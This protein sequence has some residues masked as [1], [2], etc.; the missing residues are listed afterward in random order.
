MAFAAIRP[1][2]FSRVL[3]RSIVRNVGALNF[4]SSSKSEEEAAAPPAAPAYPSFGEAMKTRAT[5]TLEV[6]VSKLFPAGFGWQAAGYFGDVS[7]GLTDTQISFFLVTGMGDLLGVFGGHCIYN[8]IKKAT[9]MGK[10]INMGDEVQTGFM[11]GTAA[12][13]SGTAW[14]PTVNMMGS[15]NLEFIPA[16]VGTGLMTGPAFFFGLRF[17]RHVYPNL[18]MSAIAR[19]DYKNCRQDAGLSTAIGA[20]C[21]MFVGTDPGLV[22][23]F[24]K[25][26]IGV[27]DAHFWFEGCKR[28]GTS[29]AVGFLAMQIVKMIM[30]QGS[31]WIDAPTKA[32]LEN[33]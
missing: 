9:P 19:P 23:N 33:K 5:V 30:P 6:M 12:F 32:E 17:A 29:T 28:A 26:I 1:T 18:G 22:G 20:A 24:M 3:N 13:C 8:L 7:L 15:M 27:E 31:N 14:Q 11:L 25:D 21:A 16:A 10:D 2:Q 4:H